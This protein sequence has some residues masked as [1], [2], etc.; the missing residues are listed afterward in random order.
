MKG[1]PDSFG[2]YCVI[3]HAHRQQGGRHL[4]AEIHTQAGPCTSVD[5]R[6]ATGATGKLGCSALGQVAKSYLKA[7]SDV[8]WTKG[9]CQQRGARLIGCTGR[10]TEL[11]RRVEE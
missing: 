10:G 5:L 11:G 1:Q 8:A 4:G 9:Y 2:Q 3:L 7:H 6:W